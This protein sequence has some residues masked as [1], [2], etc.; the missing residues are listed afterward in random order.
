MEKIK[1]KKILVILIPT[2][3]VLAFAYFLRPQY[4]L[5]GKIV[6]ST[7][8]KG[9]KNAI[10]LYGDKEFKTDEEGTF[11][12]DKASRKNS[13]VIKEIEGFEK[14]DERKIEFNN[15]FGKEE[16]EESFRI[17]PTVKTMEERVMDAGKY[18]QYD[19]SWDFMHDDDKKA[20]GSKEDY[21]RILKERDS[22][23][24]KLNSDIKSFKVGDNVRV[25]ESWKSDVSGKEYR[26]VYE[27]QVE[28]TFSD[29]SVKNT[30][31][32]WQKIDGNYFYFT[33]VKKDE[34]EKLIKD[35]NSITSL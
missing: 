32:H 6:D 23:A 7:N 5:S 12:I 19:F 27:L 18:S 29:N 10:V 20:W 13:L 34:L 15:Y 24:S 8:S 25:L 3:L 22:I 2:V 14:A 1:N 31:T 26:D 17:S 16:K 28:Q 21:L 11:K 9:I 33:S 35:Y 4:S 30:T